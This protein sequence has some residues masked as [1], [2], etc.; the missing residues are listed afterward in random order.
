MW[1]G[2][3]YKKGTE[4]AQKRAQ[5][6]EDNGIFGE[7]SFSKVLYNKKMISRLVSISLEEKGEGV[8]AG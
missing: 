6:Y 5:N 2:L 1:C 3:N 8:K 7:E 4:I